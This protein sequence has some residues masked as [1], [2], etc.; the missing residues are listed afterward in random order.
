MRA[1]AGLRMCV[2]ACMW[3]CVRL[4]TC[5]HMCACGLVLG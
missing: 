1:C 5:V 4:R 3:T 2:H